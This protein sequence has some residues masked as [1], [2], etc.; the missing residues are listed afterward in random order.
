MYPNFN[1]IAMGPTM[2]KPSPNENLK[3]AP[4]CQFV[5]NQV[6]SKVAQYKEK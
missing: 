1:Q 4:E 2:E 3:N 6:P 5:R